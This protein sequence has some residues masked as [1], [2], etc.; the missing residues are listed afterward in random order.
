MRTSQKSRQARRGRSSSAATPAADAARLLPLGALAAGLGLL[1]LPALAQDQAAA[2]PAAAAS[3]AGQQPTV[4]PG[5]KVKAKVETD[6]NSVR[7]TTTGIA[8]GQQDLRDIPQAVTVLTEKLLDDRR[9]DTVQDALRQT[10]GVSF[11]APEGGEQD[12]RLRGFSLAQT[13]DIYF[14][15]LRD[16]AFYDRDTFAFDRVELMKGSASMLF[17]RGSTGGLV[18]QSSKQAY[19]RDGYSLDVTAGDGKFGRV[20]VDL[21]KKTG[22]STALRVNAMKT[23]ADNWGNFVN[24]HG[25]AVDLRHGIGERDEFAAS[26]YHLDNFNGINYGMP[27]IRTNAAS[28]TPATIIKDMNPRNYY[29]A[30]SDYNSG[31]A[32]HGTL[33]WTRRLGIGS[34]LKTTLRHGVYVRDMRASTIRFC[35]NATTNAACSG[36]TTPGLTGSSLLT[37]ATPLQRGTN[38]KIQNLQTTN[39]Q[40]DYSFR[41]NWGGKRHDVITGIDLSQ[42]NFDGFAPNV[43]PTGVTL[44]KNSTIT[45]YGTP[46]DGSGSVDE[47][48]RLRRQASSFDTSSIGLYAQDMVWLTD[49]LKL[50]AGLR[51]DNF[52]GHYKTYQTATSTTVPIGTVTADR[53]RRDHVWS[54]RLGLIWQPS[55]LQSYHISYST[56]FN[57][58]GD[59]FQ[60]DAQGTNTPPESNRNI[61]IGSKLDL[62]ANQL[63]VRASLFH[64]TKLNERNRDSESLTPLDDYLLSGKRHV[65]G[66]D[67]DIAGRITPE[68]EAFVS[69]AWIPSAEIDKGA[70]TATGSITGELQGQRPSLTPR[71]SGSVWSTYQVLPKWRVGGG[72]N[73]RSSMTPN[74]N[75]AGI[76]A[77]KW[78]TGDLML[79]Y[80]HDDNYS[81]K[82]N[83]K[84][85]TNKLYADSI[86]S[87]H[88]VPGAP[89]TIQVTG[90]VKF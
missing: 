31:S 11:L 82:L 19:L 79:E 26:M 13:G 6:A 41:A 50:L 10:G 7:A 34:E 4:L 75:P 56:S 51:W 37:A 89:R 53:G 85:V 9:T 84:N 17:G 68:W 15:G 28:S 87:G 88:W 32:T 73:V 62:F 45:Y 57:T 72:L 80:T 30:A 65:A 63:S 43:L 81:A 42:E 58:S 23:E 38:N 83:V 3:A 44:N 77:P 55:D 36:F 25:A 1:S 33:Q 12:I 61:E 46:N 60:Y 18:N 64:A 21:N 66:L 48:Q 54:K 59:A 67:L 49:E 40:S 70:L 78:V 35:T 47:T 90:S 5:L 24:K 29:G 86:Y 8:K 22:E 39:L 16:P 27:W 69:Y 14:D 20:V 74:R 2:A 76:V 52:G 71:H